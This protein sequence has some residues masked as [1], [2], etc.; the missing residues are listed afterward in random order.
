[1]LHLHNFDHVQIQ[2]ALR[3]LKIKKEKKM[4]E[5]GGK[6]RGGRGRTWIVRTES[7][8]MGVRESAIS[9]L[10]LVLREVRAT[11]VNNS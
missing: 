6:K 8:M 11:L 1:M 9:S 2:G 5:K 10:N 7:T 3:N 4:S